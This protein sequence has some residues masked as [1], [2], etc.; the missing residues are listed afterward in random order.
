MS[1]QLNDKRSASER[2][3]GALSGV[4]EK[5][6]AACEADKGVRKSGGI[7]VFMNKYGK[8]MAAVLC[9]AL[10][11]IGYF[12]VQHVGNFSDKG[13][14][15]DSAVMNEAV[16]QEC[17]VEEAP[18]A[19]DREEED[20][21]AAVGSVEY[22]EPG[23]AENGAVTSDATTSFSD[24]SDQLIGFSG[25]TSEAEKGVA[26]EESQHYLEDSAEY[27]AQAQGMPWIGEY[28]PVV[29]PEEGAVMQLIADGGTFGNPVPTAWLFWSYDYLTDGFNV[30]VNG[31]QNYEEWIEQEIA[32][33]DVVYEA[34]YTREYVESR[35]QPV[36]GDAVGTLAL[37][38]ELVE[39]QFGVLHE[40]EEGY[41]LVRFHGV[42]TMDQIWEMMQ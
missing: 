41:V 18:K 28:V 30:Q 36:S 13:A 15:A 21:A 29:W 37:E 22:A 19:M 24:K 6:L 10:L 26:R 38:G 32:E 16:K 35:M 9:L 3:F 34:D 7:V 4:D 42:G 20:F 17:A 40:T 33:G 14:S 8:A 1:E 5:Y 39:G 23:A 12:S 25:T 11:G 2:L 27:I 31:Y